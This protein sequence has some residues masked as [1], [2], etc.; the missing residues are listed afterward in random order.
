MQCVGTYLPGRAVSF[1]NTNNFSEPQVLPAV[2]FYFNTFPRETLTASPQKWVLDSMGI[3]SLEK[4][5]FIRKCNTE[6]LSPE[7]AIKSV[8]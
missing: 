1:F 5:L 7:A 3:F 2:E 6:M 8:L 4:L